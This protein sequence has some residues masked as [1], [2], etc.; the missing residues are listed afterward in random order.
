MRSKRAASA[1]GAGGFACILLLAIC[2]WFSPCAG[3]STPPADNK[4]SAKTPAVTQ[5]PAPAQKKTES[6]K[7]QQLVKEHK[8]ITNEDL[9]GMHASEAGKGVTEKELSRASANPT[10]C[11]EEC[12]QEARERVGMGQ[13]QEGEWQAQLATARQYIATSAEWKDAYRNAFQKVQTYC[14]FQRQLQTAAPPSGNDYQ[15][16]YERAKQDEYVRQMIRTLSMGAQGASQR[17]YRLIGEAQRLDAVR[18]AVMSVLAER[19]LN[20]CSDPIDP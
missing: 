10:E 3:Q 20:Q 19:A 7:L 18:A 9:E 15:S 4:Q 6:A 8:V 5:A 1:A 13:D 16:R 12:A 17:L 14:T 11:N 2:G